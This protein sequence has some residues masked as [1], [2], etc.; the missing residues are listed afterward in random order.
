MLI[1][2]VVTFISV[3][4]ALM[5][6]GW[7]KTRHVSQE[8]TSLLADRRMGLFALTATLVMTEF[9]TST[10]IAFSSLGYL[11]GC[12]LFPYTIFNKQHSL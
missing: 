4:L 6:I 2:D 8:N 7:G 9:N 1:A 10:L 5:V 11:A 3:I 12:L